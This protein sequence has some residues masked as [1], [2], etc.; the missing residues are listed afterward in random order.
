MRGSAPRMRLL[1]RPA[2]Q[3]AETRRELK[4]IRGGRL[5]GEIHVVKRAAEEQVAQ[6]PADEPQPHLTPVGDFARPHE[7]GVDL[8]G[9]E[10]GR[11][12]ALGGHG[13]A[14]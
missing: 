14:A 13:E 11:G 12:F 4:R 5:H 9:G 2:G 3:G 7:L 8:L 10:R 6:R 1:E